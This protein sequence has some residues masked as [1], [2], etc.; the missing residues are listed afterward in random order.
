VCDVATEQGVVRVLGYFIQKTGL[1]YSFIGYAAQAQY[2]GYLST[3]EQT[4]GR[5][6]NLTEL[7]RI[8]V[9]PE[10][11]TIRATPRQTSLRQALQNFGVQQ[12]ELESHAILNGMG[13]D[14]TVPAN[15]LLKVVR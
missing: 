2:D 14:D 1:V 3:F 7:A 11:L 5:F 6:S 10:R 4:L 8:N 15:T 9:K 12:D 13:L